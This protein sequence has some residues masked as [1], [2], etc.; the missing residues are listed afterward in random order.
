MKNEAGQEKMREKEMMM[1]RALEI[2]LESQKIE[3][4]ASLLHDFDKSELRRR[5]NKKN[6]GD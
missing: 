5:K 1:M 3:R 2:L 4:G 6:K